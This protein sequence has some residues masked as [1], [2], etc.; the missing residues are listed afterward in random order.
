MVIAVVY[1]YPNLL[2][3]K[4]NPMARRFTSAYMNHPPGA[5]DHELHVVV[6]GGLEDEKPEALFDPLVP[7]FIHHN[8]SGRDIGAYFAAARTIPCDF[9]VC[10]G[11]P[12]RPR[13]AGWLDRLV[14]ALENNGPGVYGPWGFHVPAVHLRTTVFAIS[15]DLLNHYPHT[16]TD[17]YR[18]QFEH[19]P[20]SIAFWCMKK[21]F[22]AMQVTA[23]G[24]FHV[25]QWHHVEEQDS[26]FGDQHSD[27]L[28][29][30]DQL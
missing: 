1:V 17:D 10:I 19:G 5:T 12:A 4:Y 27:Q 15:P 30:K 7:K 2:H 21:G 29:W 9:M 13:I 26:L 20:D 3:A 23:S 25:E 22:Q 18:Y 8:N 24:V 11:A 6:N 28:G 16:V 14:R